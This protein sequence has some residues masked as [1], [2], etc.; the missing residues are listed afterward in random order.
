MRRFRK[1]LIVAVTI[2]SVMMPI[3]AFAESLCSSDEKSMF[4]C[5][6]EKSQKSVSICQSKSNPQNIYYKFG[7]SQKVDITLPTEKTGKPYLVFEQFGPAATQWLQSICF[8]SGKVVYCLT[9]PQGIS[10]NLAVEGIKKPLS[11]TCESGDSG[12]ELSDAYNEMEKLKFK[13]K[14]E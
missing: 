13:V 3:I 2:I 8:P 11:M 1:L 5:K 12:P 14:Q 4:S 9:T 10:V 6:L 7:T